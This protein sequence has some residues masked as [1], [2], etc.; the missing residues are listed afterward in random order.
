VLD[1][2]DHARGVAPDRLP[3]GLWH[4]I[5]MIDHQKLAVTTC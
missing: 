5:V 1:L 2:D 4:S 3:K